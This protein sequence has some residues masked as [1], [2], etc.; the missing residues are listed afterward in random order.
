M[1][2]ALDAAAANSGGGNAVFGNITLS[3]SV[4]HDVIVL[5]VFNELGSH[6]GNNPIAI[7]GV[8][9]TAGLTW[10]KRSSKTFGKGA[11][12]IWYAI[13]SAML[14]SDTITFNFASTTD[15]WSCMAFAV[16]GADTSSPWDTNGALPASND[17]LGGTPSVSVSTTARNAFVFAFA[18]S[19]SY[20]SSSSPQAPL[21]AVT[22]PSNTA[23][24]Q[25]FASSLAAY[26]IETSPQ[27]SLSLT[28]NSIS[29]AWG[30]LG[31][32]IVE[33]GSGDGGSESEPESE[34]PTVFAFFDGVAIN[35]AVGGSALYLRLSTNAADDVII[36]ALTWEG[37]NSVTGITDSAGLTWTQRKAGSISGNAGGFGMASGG[38]TIWYAVAPDALTDDLITVSMASGPTLTGKGVAGIA[39]AVHGIDISSPCD[40]N[41]SLPAVSQGAAGTHSVT[42]STDA[43]KVLLLG[44]GPGLFSYSRAEPPFFLVGQATLAPVL[45][46]SRATYWG[47]SPS[48]SVYARWGNDDPIL[49]ENVTFTAFGA[50]G[51]TGV[52]VDALRLVGEY[53]ASGGPF[54]IDGQASGKSPDYT[55]QN[56]VSA[57][58]TTAFGND[59]IVAVVHNGGFWSH[60]QA[61][62]SITDD[63]GLE[64]KKRASVKEPDTNN[65]FEVWYAI[66][67]R[68][69]VNDTIRVTFEGNTDAASLIV[70]GV[71][72]ADLSRIW[73]PHV[74][75]P[76]QNAGWSQPS[77]IGISTTAKV[78]MLLALQGTNTTALVSGDT[79]HGWTTIATQAQPNPGAFSYGSFVGAAY[80]IADAR[81]HD[82]HTSMVQEGGR[83]NS[84]AIFGDAIVAA[85]QSAGLDD[86]ESESEPPS[87]GGSEH[88]SEPSSEPTSEPGSE[89]QSEPE[90]EPTSEGPTL[91][92]PV[93][94]TVIS[95]GV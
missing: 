12:E 45:Y 43:S 86:S 81:Q 89:L 32:A 93:Q 20:F 73:D 10:T 3:T 1:G 64:W 44:F 16:S 60:G 13:A 56:G 39:F 22:A 23:W 72:G 35:A 51:A 50:A 34:V 30:M 27:S 5:C 63:A 87:E 21:T 24:G 58:L 40:T 2:L 6:N 90:S 37:S 82:T 76:A 38:Y 19:E 92:P 70:F 42:V 47:Y 17:G 25:E 74:A 85:D 49:S 95:I 46:P 94:M 28:Y 69:L 52:V 41:A 78:T 68:P 84:W 14:S 66:A 67:K 7:S 62:A 61:V 91:P 55:V 4:A 31:D 11:V 48:M 75:L 80:K 8:S 83:F 18:G 88:P 71:S 15:D 9:D 29:G 57:T 77:D 54:G 53:G 65:D 33:G 59:A 36:V 26:A 79:D